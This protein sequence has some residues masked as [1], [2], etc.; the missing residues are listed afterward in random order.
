MVILNL[1]TQITTQ[2]KLKLLSEAESQKTLPI[3]W[4]LVQPIREKGTTIALILVAENRDTPIKVP[5]D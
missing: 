4:L 3:D 5:T 1:D 2:Q